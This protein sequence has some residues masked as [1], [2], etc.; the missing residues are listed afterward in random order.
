MQI[1]FIFGGV[2]TVFNGQ[3]FKYFEISP[4]ITYI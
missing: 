2:L 4:I 3:R 1:K